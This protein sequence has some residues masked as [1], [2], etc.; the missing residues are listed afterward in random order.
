MLRC[1]CHCLHVLGVVSQC[2]HTDSLSLLTFPLFKFSYR[3]INLFF[4]FHNFL[5]PQTI[6]ASRIACDSYRCRVDGKILYRMIPNH[7][8]YLL[9]LD[10]YNNALHL[11][12]SRVICVLILLFIFIINCTYLLLLAIIHHQY[13][14]TKTLLCLHTILQCIY[15]HNNT[16]YCTIYYTLYEHSLR[17]G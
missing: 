15:L 4:N 9:C 10:T 12:N 17:G 13:L 11:L 16:T 2:I 5:F 6:L 1:V 7:T 8:V 3:I 14:R